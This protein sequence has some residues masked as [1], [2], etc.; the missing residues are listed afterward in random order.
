MTIPLRTVC[1]YATL[2]AV[3]CACAAA[4]RPRSATADP[5]A[6][7]AQPRPLASE[8]SPAPST[9]TEAKPTTD[10]RQLTVI[11]TPNQPDV[12]SAKLSELGKRYSRLG[13]RWATQGTQAFGSGAVLVAPSSNSSEQR[14]RVFVITNR[15]VVG[16]AETVNLTF[17]TTNHEQPGKVVYVDEPY[18]LAIIEVE[19]LTAPLVGFTLESQSVHDQDEVIASGYPGIDGHPSYQ[20]TRGYVSNE[21]VIV[22]E[23]DQVPYIQHTAPIDPGS[24]GGPLTTARGSLV[25]IN[26]LKLRDR[27]A[28]GMAVPAR[29]IVRALAELQSPAVPPSANGACERLAALLSHEE[30]P[31]ALL[32]A[33]AAQLVSEAGPKS[34]TWLGKDAEW[35]ERFATDPITVL[36]LA[37]AV[38]LWV[39]LKG[40]EPKQPVLCERSSHGQALALRA[41]GKSYP[42][43]FSLEQA[44]FKLSKVA[45]TGTNGAGFLDT[46]APAK[47]W[48]PSLR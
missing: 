32:A 9:P 15:H 16:F 42:V 43:E 34:L 31:Q 13:G 20:V 38:R 23:A 21:R 6:Q 39:Q 46:F 37:V 25:G 17:P 28:V 26:T 12:I 24:S 36:T 3:L 48:K 35:R 33:F 30:P 1:V 8:D 47:T 5:P 22:D 18:D 10:L 44:R 4:P 41:R 45:L 19:G 7:T 27:E 2:G 11:V 40:N 14:P 29:A